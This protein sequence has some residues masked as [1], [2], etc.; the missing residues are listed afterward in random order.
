MPLFIAYYQNVSVYILAA[1]EAALH[2][3]RCPLQLNI[4][5]RMYEHL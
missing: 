4:W 5:G 3:F 2:V 1:R